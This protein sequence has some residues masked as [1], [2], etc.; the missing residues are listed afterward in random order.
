MGCGTPYAKCWLRRGPAG[1]GV[2]VSFV[3]GVDW[4]DTWRFSGD[5]GG[6]LARWDSEA[7][8][9]GGSILA[10]WPCS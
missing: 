8:W 3:A 2:V 9:L 7:S 5:M 4:A 10:S 1:D 6:V